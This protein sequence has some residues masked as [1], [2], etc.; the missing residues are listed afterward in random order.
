MAP[1]SIEISGL[2]NEEQ[3]TLHQY[4]QKAKSRLIEYII[5]YFGSK[6]SNIENFTYVSVTLVTRNILNNIIMKLNCELSLQRRSVPVLYKDSV[7]TAL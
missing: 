6:S 7:H 3:R 1:C 2:R 5:I 4:C